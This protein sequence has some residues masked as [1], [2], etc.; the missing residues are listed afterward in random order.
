MQAI[1]VQP[2]TPSLL[3]LDSSHTG[4]VSCPMTSRQTAGA[5]TTRKTSRTKVADRSHGTMTP[6]MY[7][8][9]GWHWG[10]SLQGLSTPRESLVT[11]MPPRR[12]KLLAARGHIVPSGS[13]PSHSKWWDGTTIY[14]VMRTVRDTQSPMLK[15]EKQISTSLSRTDSAPESRL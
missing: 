13:F 3:D 11:A 4:E 8:A 12:F 5:K 10:W 6:S 15:G 9:V 2:G 1:A 14:M 7:T